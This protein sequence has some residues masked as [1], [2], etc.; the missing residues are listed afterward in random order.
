MAHRPASCCKGSLQVAVGNIDAC[1]P[2]MSSALTIHLQANIHQ[3]HLPLIDTL[4]GQSLLNCD[5]PL[6]V[7]GPCLV[8]F[9]EN[10]VAQS[11]VP[12]LLDCDVPVQVEGPCLVIFKG[13]TVAQSHV[14]SFLDCDVPVQAEG[15]Y[16]MTVPPHQV[17]CHA[18]LI[19]M[20]LFR[21]RAPALSSSR[22]TLSPR[23]TSQRRTFGCRMQWRH[24]A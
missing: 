12:C 5:M 19:V 2:K 10:T 22:T 3:L 6:Q 20:C 8:I 4:K 16:L 7:E 18:C 1:F 21:L 13:N 24:T 9:K 23:V 11:H 14:P 17:L 15:S